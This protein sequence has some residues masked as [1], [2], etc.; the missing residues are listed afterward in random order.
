MIENRRTRH[1]IIS[2][3]MI[4]AGIILPMTLHAVPNGGKIFLPMRLPVMVAAFFLPWT[5]AGAVGLLTP[6]LSSV[7]IGMPPLVPIPMA[8]IM[9]FELATYA[10]IIALLKKM[11]LEDN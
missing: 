1:M 9:P 7:L 11:G 8:I 10:I 6:I 4:A 2:A 5:W 3:V